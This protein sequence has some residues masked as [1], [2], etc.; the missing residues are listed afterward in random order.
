MLPYLLGLASPVEFF[1]IHK[2]A[3][4][5]IKGIYSNSNNKTLPLVVLDL[6]SQV[7]ESNAQ[8]TEIT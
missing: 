2:F 7:Q 3:N 4:F 1:A 6:I 5:G 8:P